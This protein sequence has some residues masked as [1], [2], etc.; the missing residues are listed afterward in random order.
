KSPR[1]ICKTGSATWHMRRAIDDEYGIKI[2]FPQRD[3]RILSPARDLANYAKFRT[4]KALCF[5]TD[6]A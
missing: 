5:P 4:L 1:P 2:P 3:L 6:S